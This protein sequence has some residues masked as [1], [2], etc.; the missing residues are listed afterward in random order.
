MPKA[1]SCHPYLIST[2]FKAAHTLR[3][4]RMAKPCRPG[5]IST[6]F[7]AA[8]TLLWFLCSM[9]NAKSI[10]LD[11]ISATFN[12]AFGVFIRLC[13]V[14]SA[15]SSGF[16]LI[17][18][19]FVGAFFWIAFT[20]TSMPLANP[21]TDN[22]IITIFSAA[23]TLTSMFAAKSSGLSLISTI[24]SNTFLAFT[25]P[26]PTPLTISSTSGYLISTIFSAA[27]TL[28]SMSTATSITDG[29]SSATFNGAQTSS[30]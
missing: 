18:T 9:P 11:Y 26:S 8:H 22:Y 14:S 4:V 25:L 10:I 13:P 27:D 28:T 16:S 17:R 3:S 6:T 30:Y 29:S 21:F 24:F 23:D 12:P 1:T 7:K 5:L 20:P 19:T 2:T 15:A